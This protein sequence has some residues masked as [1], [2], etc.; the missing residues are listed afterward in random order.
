MVFFNSPRIPPF[1]PVNVE[2]FWWYGFVLDLLNWGEKRSIVANFF[3]GE[4][5]TVGPPS[6]GPVAC[7]S[8]P[9]MIIRFS[10]LYDSVYVCVRIHRA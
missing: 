7:S 2:V 5:R 3:L 8:P 4:S 6:Q 1:L 10:V 9:S